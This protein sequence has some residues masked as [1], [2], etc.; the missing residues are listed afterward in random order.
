MRILL[1]KTILEVEP[2]SICMLLNS[3]LT[4]FDDELYE[5]LAI[6]ISD[7][8]FEC[9]K[10]IEPTVVENYLR[11]KKIP[12]VYGDSLSNSRLDDFEGYR[13]LDNG[14]LKP[15]EYKFEVKPYLISFNALGSPISYE[16]VTIL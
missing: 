3:D 15:L 13:L 1:R 5:I 2:S 11:E 7:K 16:E 12:C 8:E 10:V 9:L 14:V 4:E 6:K